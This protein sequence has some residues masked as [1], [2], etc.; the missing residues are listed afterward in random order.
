MRAFF[1]R[2][3]CALIFFHV[4]ARSLFIVVLCRTCRAVAWPALGVR[5]SRD[6]PAAHAACA[7]CDRG[8]AG[9]EPTTSRSRSAYPATRP[10]SQA[11]CNMAACDAGAHAA[12]QFCGR[13][14]RALVT[15]LMVALRPSPSN[16]AALFACCVLLLCAF[17]L[18]AKP[19]RS[20]ALGNFSNGHKE[21]SPSVVVHSHG[22]VWHVLAG[23][24]DAV[25]RRARTFGTARHNTLL[26]AT[27][28]E[29]RG[30]GGR[31]VTQGGA[32]RVARP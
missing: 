15:S 27:A 14:P 11:H 29:G 31:A 24:V 6:W 2:D 3:C 28:Y 5:A 26:G 32:G 9:I 22:D 30:R 4:S 19:A 25:V 23:D 1:L 12:A 17:A 18:E 20:G 16:R 21:L 13:C 8:T 7:M 10:S